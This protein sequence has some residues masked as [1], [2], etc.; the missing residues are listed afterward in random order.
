MKKDRF[1]FLLQG[2]SVVDRV[3]SEVEEIDIA[4]RNDVASHNDV[5]SRLDV[6]KMSIFSQNQRS[7]FSLSNNKVSTLE[8]P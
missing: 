2:I 5:T 4:S 7:P 6:T 8:V 1:F 3:E